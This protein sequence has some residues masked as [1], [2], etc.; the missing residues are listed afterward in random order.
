MVEFIDEAT[1]QCLWLGL[2]SSSE[3]ETVQTARAA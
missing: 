2:L 1:G 3:I